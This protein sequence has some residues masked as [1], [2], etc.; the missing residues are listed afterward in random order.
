M[1]DASV[2]AQWLEID[3]VSGQLVKAAAV[4]QRILDFD[5][6]MI[7]AAPVTSWQRTISTSPG[8]RSHYAHLGNP[9][10]QNLK[11]S[12]LTHVQL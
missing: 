8:L 9:R 6:W 12:T 7:E 1:H 10:I 11:P 5:Q 3:E 2:P 4:G